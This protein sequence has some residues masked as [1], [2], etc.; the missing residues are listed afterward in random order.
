MK[1]Y[2]TVGAWEDHFGLLGDLKE[3]ATETTEAI[4]FDLILQVDKLDLG[5]R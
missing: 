1:I 3:G 5:K 4:A 2:K